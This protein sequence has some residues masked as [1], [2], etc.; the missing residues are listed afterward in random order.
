M[1]VLAQLFLSKDFEH[2]ALSDSFDQSSIVGAF[3][4]A[5]AEKLNALGQLFAATKPDKQPPVPV[6][7]TDM[8]DFD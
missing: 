1:N 7:E 5:C 2:T 4:L 8:W 6:G 3:L